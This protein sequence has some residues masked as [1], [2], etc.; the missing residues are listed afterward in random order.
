MKKVLVVEDDEELITLIEN[1]LKICNYESRVAWS[2]EQALSLVRSSF[3]PDLIL[4]DIGLQGVD[5]FYVLECLKK[6]PKT[7]S[8][9]VLV[10]SSYTKKEMIQKARALGAADYV[11]KPF[12]VSDLTQRIKKILQSAI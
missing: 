6:D 3:R 9:P 5:G 11:T 8:I 2:G 10:C 12:E 7:R 1:L 4:L